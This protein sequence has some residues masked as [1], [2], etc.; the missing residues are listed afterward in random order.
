MPSRFIRSLFVLAPATL[1]MT[2]RGALPAFAQQAGPAADYLAYYQ[3][4]THIETSPEQVAEVR[5]LKLRRDRAEFYFAEGKFYLM[6]P[7]GGRVVAVGFRGTGRFDYVPATVM[8]QE[9]LK[10]NRKDLEVH[11]PFREVVILFADSTLEELRRQLSF[12][13]GEAS[14]DLRDRAREAF[15]YLGSNQDNAFDPDVLLPFLNGSHSDLFYAHMAFR[16]DPFV[17][18]IDPKETEGVQFLQR[19]KGTGFTRYME[20]ITRNRRDGEDPFAVEAERRPEA[21]VGKYTIE[22]GMTQD[23]AG[24]LRFRA[25]ARLEITSDTAAGPWIAFDIF[26]K[27]EIDSARTDAGEPA[28][29]FKAKDHDAVYLRLNQPLQPGAVVP[30]TLYYHGNVVDRFG[31]W[32]FINSSIAWY[33][34]ALDGRSRALFDLTFHHPRSLTLAGVGT[35]TD[36]TLDGTVET[37]RW[38]TARPIRNA[39]FNVGIFDTREVSEPGLP[40]ITLLASERGHRELFGSASGFGGIVRRVGDDVT[41]A[42][43]FFQ[44]VYGTS[45]VERFY[46]TEIP[47]LHGEAFPGLINLSYAT[48]KPTADDG[49]DEVFRAHEVAHQWWG[50]GVDYATYHDRWISEGFAD[51]SGLWFLQTRRGDNKRYFKT[52]DR[53]RAD[54]MVRRSQP[55]PIWLGH[56]VATTRTGDDYDAIVYKKGAWVLHMLRMLTLD[57]RTMNEDRFTGIMK[58]FYTTYAGRRASTED[59]RRIVEKHVGMDMRWFFDEWVY[60][61]QV[62]T[63]RVAWKSEPTDDG[64]YRVRLRVKQEDV[65]P[66]FVMYVPV[67]LELD[68]KQLARVR[69]KVTGAES[70]IDLPLMPSR[71]KDVRFNDMQSVLADV[72]TTGW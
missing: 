28:Q 24:D 25:R 67:L 69:V 56:R 66:D 57:L 6:T 19:G 7:V 20:A 45:P 43:R 62:P 29:V 54:I 34:V 46:A 1:L 32:F 42:M 27:L 72:K 23:L 44:K 39:S 64:R 47:W 36:S 58:D 21:R 55:L 37:V 31:E 18:M 14:G 35:R 38:V 63:Y 22:I 2:V 12:G 68:G 3:E 26:P 17:F 40:A 11:E 49:S 16:G 70:E 9:R 5:D 51:F 48:F 33:P 10:E 60:R 65:P 71:P 50:I 52:L 61:W 15:S 8:E 13:P 41:E 53:W 30:L 4:L 59:F